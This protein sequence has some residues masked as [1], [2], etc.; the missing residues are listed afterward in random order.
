MFTCAAI[1]TW[2]N[3]DSNCPDSGDMRP[4]GLK[5]SGM[6][7]ALRGLLCFSATSTTQALRYLARNRFAAGF[8][9]LS[10]LLPTFA[11]PINS[12]ITPRAVNPPPYTV[13]ARVV[14][15]VLAILSTVFITVTYVV[16]INA[17]RRLSNTSK[18]P[19]ECI[20]QNIAGIL[21]LAWP[22][23]SS[24]TQCLHDNSSDSRTHAI[25]LLYCA[26]LDEDESK[27]QIARGI[28]ECEAN[29]EKRLT[30]PPLWL[31]N[32][33]SSSSS[34]VQ[35]MVWEWVFMWLSLWMFIITLLHNGFHTDSRAPDGFLRLTMVLAYLF[36][37]GIH[38]VYVWISCTTWF[39]NVA[40][41]AAWSFLARARFTVI[42]LPQF[43]YRLSNRSEQGPL[44]LRE[45][46]AASKEFVQ[47]F[48][49]G[50]FVHNAYPTTPSTTAGSDNT[51]QGGDTPAEAPPRPRQK[52]IENALR[53]VDTSKQ[54]A[55]TDAVD[56]A[57]NALER[58][59]ANGMFVV[60]VS[61]S[62][63]FLVWT[64]EAPDSPNSQLGSLALLSSLSLGVAA[65][66]TSA[67]Y[68]QTMNSSFR[69]LLLMKEILINGHA[70]EF[71]TK[72][73]PSLPPIS[74]MQGTANVR[75]MH[76]HDFA[77]KTNLW[78]I[79]LFVTFGPGYFLL[80]TEADQTMKSKEAE[81]ELEIPVRGHMV[82]F[83]TAG[84]DRHVKDEY[85]QNLHAI[86]VCYV[87]TT[88]D[89]RHT[90]ASV[91]FSEQLNLTTQLKVLT[92]RNQL[93]PKQVRTRM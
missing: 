61:I 77:G 48:L 46:N 39:T 91:T 16:L 83:T 88:A 49:D 86:N 10:L 57:L 90:S 54:I 65:M 32:G 82:R 58:V 34:I 53:N 20:R 7:S 12:A 55:R 6:F 74:F 89:N 51:I 87:P 42:D 15:T 56:G 66:F 13:S 8:V 68:L 21:E 62:S 9:F 2:S 84:T 3:N 79:L 73:P 1:R 52:D 31:T 45:I 27:G 43:Q 30:A 85:G 40:A 44:K 41:G 93:C 23:V 18:L 25:R 24:S 4:V 47:E 5:S 28:L 70:E 19:M 63:G 67:V 81:F 29:P 38:F 59:I 64:T 80:P 50:E 35:V 76:M 14:E 36:A 37:F 11:T 72:R 69:Q 92:R 75:R 60:A 26:T 22:N 17:G 78:S 33:S 71:S